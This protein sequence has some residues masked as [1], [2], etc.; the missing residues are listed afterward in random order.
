M[1]C[2]LRHKWSAWTAASTEKL[3]AV[4]GAGDDRRVRYRICLRCGT[5]EVRNGSD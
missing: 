4:V 2:L 1:R 3:A 5:S